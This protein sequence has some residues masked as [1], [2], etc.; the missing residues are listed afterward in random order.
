MKF[1]QNWL[2]GFDVTP[3]PYPKRGSQAAFTLFS[4]SLIECRRG[5]AAREIDRNA[6]RLPAPPDT[7]TASR[8]TSITEEHPYG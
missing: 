5:P 8:R 3:A 6:T 4:K 1:L 2:C 7:W